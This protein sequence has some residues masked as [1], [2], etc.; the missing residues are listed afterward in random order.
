V[1][2]NLLSRI[3]MSEK[4]SSANSEY[5]GLHLCHTLWRNALIWPCPIWHF[6][7]GCGRTCR[8]DWQWN[9]GKCHPRANCQILFEPEKRQ[10]NTQGF[11]L[12]K[13]LLHTTD[14][15]GW[16]NWQSFK[17]SQLSLCLIAYLGIGTNNLN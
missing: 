16:F 12:N 8:Y 7:T 3:K 9:C 17:F 5:D 13:W 10:W 4:F 14:E 15:H 11:V 2:I 1:E 6:Y